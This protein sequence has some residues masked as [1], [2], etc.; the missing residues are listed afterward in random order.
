MTLEELTNVKPGTMLLWELDHPMVVVPLL[1]VF[2]LETPVN[3]KEYGISVTFK[4]SISEPGGSSYF[5]EMFVEHDFELE[6][7]RML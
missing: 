1:R 4:A 2:V 7:L 6:E 3:H 5:L